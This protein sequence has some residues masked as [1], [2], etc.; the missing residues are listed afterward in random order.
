MGHSVGVTDSY[1]KPTEDEMLTEYLKA[2]VDLTILDTEFKPAQEDIEEL[3]LEN[4]D[5]KKKY[6]TIMNMIKGLK[7]Q[8]QEYNSEIQKS[9]EELA[10]NKKERERVTKEINELKKKQKNEKY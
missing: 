2:V 10:N 3:K 5:L 8:M 9:N 7:L 4:R 1:Y 6:S